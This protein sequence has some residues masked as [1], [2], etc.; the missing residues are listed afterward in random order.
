MVRLNKRWSQVTLP[1]LK[2]K[3]KRKFALFRIQK[4]VYLLHFQSN[5]KVFFTFNQ[6]IVLMTSSYDDYFIISFPSY[7]QNNT[8]S[9]NN[10]KNRPNLLESNRLVGD[11]KVFLSILILLTLMWLR[12][13]SR[14]VN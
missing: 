8:N 5:Q 4:I 14:F 6:I 9:Q 13:L 12:L 2:R 7:I 1:I 11:F 10:E 3:L